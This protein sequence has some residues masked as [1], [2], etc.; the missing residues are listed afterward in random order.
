M[1]KMSLGKTA[2]V[3]SLGRAEAGRPRHC[4]GTRDSGRNRA[5][6][7]VGRARRVAGDRAPRVRGRAPR[8]EAAPPP[9]ELPGGEFA[10]QL[11]YGWSRWGPSEPSGNRARSLRG[12]AASW[13]ALLDVPAEG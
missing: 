6:A 9:G 12:A 1:R 11:T 4:L 8:K 13:D 7:G 2:K 5:A 3:R 10:P